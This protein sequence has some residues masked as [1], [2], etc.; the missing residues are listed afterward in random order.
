MGLATVKHI[1]PTPKLSAPKEIICQATLKAIITCRYDVLANYTKSLKQTYIEELH[2]LRQF[3]P[4]DA[5][6]LQS[7]KP[8]LASY[9]K[10]LCDFDRS[11][12]LEV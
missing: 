5:R 3:A 10:I 11:R 8:L 4:Q 6:S 7:I 1:V 12:L 2:K 9:D